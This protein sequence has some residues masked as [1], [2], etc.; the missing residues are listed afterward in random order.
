MIEK[1]ISWSVHNRL[2]VWGFVVVLVIAGSWSVITTPVDA[3]PDLSE[4]QVIVYTEWMGRNPQIMEDQVT[5]P[6]VS[7]MQGISGVKSV[8][9]SSMF[10]MSFIFIIFND[11]TDIYW[12][13]TRVLEKLNY[14]QRFLPEGVIPTLGPDGTGVGH[15]Y[16]YVL[17]APDYDLGEQRAIQDWYVKLALQNVEGVSE[18]ASFGGFQKQYQVVVNP[19]RL[20][21]YN[22]MYSDLIKALRENNRDVGGSTFEIASTGMMIRGLG[23]IED[24]E[25]IK[26]IMVT[27][28]NG[29]PVRIRDVATIQEGGE[30]RLG[31]TEENGNGE[32]VGGIIVMRY[33]ENP[34][35]VIDR[36]KER[37]VDV[38]KGLPPGI[39]FRTVYDRSTLI[40][41]A[42]ATL[43]ETLIEEI[44]IVSIVVLIFIFHV[45]SALVVILTIPLSVL[46]GFILIKVTGISLNIM[47]LGG[48]VLA[49]GDLVDAGI[50]MVENTYKKL[51]EMVIPAEE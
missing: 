31:I 16:W 23:Y 37:M 15:I 34:E 24:I 30:F 18:V 29:V 27:N 25:S 9:A 2:I 44:I 45:R 28:R 36:V 41:A 20:S 35:E 19:H 11:D 33:G 4:N 12:A 22:L 17:D 38:S 3:I 10:G 1:I 50:V 21:T 8:R 49:I 39:T 7:N 42:M 48:I 14:A 40:D 46:I 26:N 13:R 6:L 51:T 47:S 32:V 5:Y 43:R